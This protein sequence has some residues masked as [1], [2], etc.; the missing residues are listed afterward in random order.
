MCLCTQ[1]KEGG[2]EGGGAEDG[3]PQ[4][5]HEVVQIDFSLLD[6]EIVRTPPSLT[7]AIVGACIGGLIMHD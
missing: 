1:R 4:Q 7:P 3:Q 5:D 6:P 2:A